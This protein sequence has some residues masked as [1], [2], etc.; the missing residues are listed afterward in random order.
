[1]APV[2]VNITG[3]RTPHCKQME[4]VNE[5]SQNIQVFIRCRPLNEKNN[6]KK[7]VV[8]IVPERREVVVKER[9]GG[10]AGERFNRNFYYDDVFDTE[11]SQLEVYRAVVEPLIDQ[12]LAGYNCTVFAYGQTGTGKTFTMEGDRS[13]QECSW[14]DDPR[15]GIIPRALAQLFE[16]LVCENTEYTVSVSFMELYNEELYDLLSPSEE[17]IR[18]KIYD[19]AAKKG[20]V[21]VGGLCEVNVNS[22][23]EIYDILQ[24]GSAK[25]QTA[26]TKLNACSSRSHTIFAVTV[27][28]KECSHDGEELLKIGKLNLVDLAGSE[29]IGR[30]GATEK[31]AREA[32]NINQSLLTLGRV[33]TN[34]VEKQPHVPY[35]ES[36]LTRLLRDSLGGGTKTSII[37]TISPNILDVEDTLSTLEYAQRAKKITNKPEVNQKLSK[38]TLLREYTQEIEKLRRELGAVRGGSTAFFVDKDNYEEMCATVEKQF[39]DIEEKEANIRSLQEEIERVEGLYTTTNTELEEKRERLTQTTETLQQTEA[40]LTETKNVLCEVKRDCS[41][42]KHLVEIHVKTEEVLSGQANQL[43]DV[44]QTTTDHITKL[45]TK[46][47]RQRS[48]EQSNFENLESFRKQY[49]L[50]MSRLETAIKDCNN[51]YLEDLESNVKGRF[52]QIFAA[53]GEIQTKLNDGTSTWNHNLDS[54]FRQLDSDNSIAEGLNFVTDST[55]N[56]QTLVSSHYKEVT[57]LFSQNVSTII[58]DVSKVVALIAEQRSDVEQMLMKQNE[59]IIVAQKARE[60]EFDKILSCIKQSV[61]AERSAILKQ[62]A[63]TEDLQIKC[64]DFS[65]S[66]DDKISKFE[67]LIMQQNNLLAEMKSSKKKELTALTDSVSQLESNLSETNTAAQQRAESNCSAVDESRSTLESSDKNAIKLVN[68][69]DALIAQ[70]IQNNLDV[71]TKS[72]ATLDEKLGEVGKFVEDKENQTVSE[73]RK[74]FNLGNG[75][76]SIVASSL[77]D[78]KTALN[79]ANSVILTGFSNTESSRVA[80]LE[81]ASEAVDSISKDI[82]MTKIHYKGSEKTMLKEVTCR[83]ADFEKLITD[84]LAKDIPSGQTPQKTTYSYPTE[85]VSTSPHERVLERF[86]GSVEPGFASVTEAPDFSDESELHSNSS[87]CSLESNT[88]NSMPTKK[89]KQAGVKPATSKTS[90]N[91]VNSSSNSNLKTGKEVDKFVKPKQV[92]K[93][94]TSN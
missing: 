7:N 86:R 17:M 74:M 2:Q 14:E 5:I 79:N 10:S 67:A 24:K 6:E 85:L 28:I 63:A 40:S 51:G 83:V 48:I 20:K 3:P 49:R 58:S 61:E 37:A 27:R 52:D 50:N 77:S 13:D 75:L 19:D 62:K 73:I 94:K 66:S 47:D 80:A 69:L 84:N 15:C 89:K 93:A 44:A 41:E 39:K 56:L 30:S 38:K 76:V 23:A 65:K 46:V 53:V 81:I 9:N 29:N 36:K 31:R 64:A 22:K 32:G 72:S 91:K 42:Q 88:E 21:I 33:I 70:N 18:L 1:M 4:P 59:Q 82:T 43:L 16:S 11:T 34:L 92:L 25:R 55:A 60:N 87:T 90:L 45:H 54:M 78:R 35:R 12:V 71:L 26:A 68:E 8:E 57:E